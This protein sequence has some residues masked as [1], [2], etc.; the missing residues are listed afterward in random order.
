M[1][2]VKDTDIP[3]AYLAAALVVD[4]ASA[5]ELRWRDRPGM[6]RKWNSRY[7]GEQAGARNTAGYFRI[8]LT[9]DGRKRSLS[10][11]RV[12]FALANGHWPKN[13]VDHKNRNC[14]DNAVE[15]LRDATN[16]QNG[17]NRGSQANNRS[18]VVGVGWEKAT[19]KWAAHIH[20]NGRTYRHRFSTFDEAVAARR[21]LEI[22]L[23]P[24]RF[25]GTADRST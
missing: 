25:G 11:H 24:F 13:Y 21:A 1:S 12:I 2:H 10:A 20:A 14:G 23:R 7:A 5:S 22:K 17:Q 4:P 18:G 6:P 8:K 19:N 3:I 15:N 9:T 16:A